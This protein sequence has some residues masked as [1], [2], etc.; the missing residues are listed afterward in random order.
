VCHPIDRNALVYLV[1]QHM[2]IH[3]WCCPVFSWG[4][5]GKTSISAVRPTVTMNVVGNEKLGGLARQVED[6]LKKAVGSVS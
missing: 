1:Y 6:K 4:Q 2:R 3:R 5:E